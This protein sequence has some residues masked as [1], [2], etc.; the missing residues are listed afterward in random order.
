MNSI[1]VRGIRWLEIVLKL[2]FVP[3]LKINL[4]LE[5]VS[6]SLSNIQMGYENVR[7]RV[8]CHVLC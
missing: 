6:I 4:V 8:D 1:Y 2:I 5:E 7:L 3:S